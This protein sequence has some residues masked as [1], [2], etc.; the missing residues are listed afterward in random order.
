MDV[1]TR[2]DVK[3]VQLA[4]EDLRVLRNFST[5]CCGK[6]TFHDHLITS[7][8]RCVHWTVSEH[9]GLPEQ[10]TTNSMA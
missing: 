10:I 2:T 9:P 5:V 8:G 3:R 4:W 7:K 1:L 6:E